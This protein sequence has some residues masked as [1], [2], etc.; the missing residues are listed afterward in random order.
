MHD[1]IPCDPIQGKSQGHEM[2][3]VIN[4]NIFYVYLLFH[5]KLSWQMTTDSYTRAEYLN[6]Y[7][8]D[9]LY[10][11]SFLCHMISKCCNIVEPVQR[12][13]VQC[14]RLVY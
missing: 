5:L 14:T 8:L 3:K 1:G 4:S 9:F 6:L 12:T 10:L 7:W 13:A 11:A 2:L